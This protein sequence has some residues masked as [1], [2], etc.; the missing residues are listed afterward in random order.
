MKVKNLSSLVHLQIYN[1]QN[2]KHF[3]VIHRAQLPKP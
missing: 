3:I 2:Q 1:I